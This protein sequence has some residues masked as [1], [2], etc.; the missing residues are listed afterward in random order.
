MYHEIE[1]KFLVMKMPNLDGIPK[2]LQERCF[3]QRGDLFEECVKRKNSVFQ[4][5]SKFTLSK[6]ERAREKLKISKEEFEQLEQKSD[7]IV[8][9]ES[10]LVSKKDPIISIKKYKGDFQGLVLA[11]VNFDS[12]RAMEEFVP[13]TWMG[14][15]VTDTSLGKDSL[16]IDLSRDKFKRIVHEIEENFNFDSN[17]GSFL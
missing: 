3:L 17:S 1:R 11:E 6:K 4:Y 10:Y 7:Y 13:L 2:V 15:E 9:S 12:I 8:E 5:E 16:L 14:A